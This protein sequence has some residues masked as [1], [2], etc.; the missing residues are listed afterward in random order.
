MFGS[1]VSAISLE[2]RQLN[3]GRTMGAK[4]R[5]KDCVVE[6]ITT[7][8]K[9]SYPGP[10]CFTHHRAFKNKRRVY[11]HTEHIGKTY[12]ITG[13]EYQAIY[14]AQGGK[15][16]ICQRATGAKRKLAVDHDH[17]TGYVRGLLC[18]MCNYR[19]LGHLRDD[20]ESLQR[21]IDYINNPPAFRVIGKR[22]VPD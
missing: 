12:G 22:K 4:K 10:R 2:K 1:A 5:C 6:G 15:C 17:D 8:R 19:V 16:Y 20:T 13:E 11:N 3:G 14:E 7:Q 18:K 21:A 9:A